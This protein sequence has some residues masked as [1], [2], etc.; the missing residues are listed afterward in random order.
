MTQEEI[1]K[2]CNDLIEEYKAN[3]WRDALD[4]IDERLRHYGLSQDEYKQA[5]EY[6]FRILSTTP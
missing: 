1:I 3:S 6:I 2:L 4:L 5:S